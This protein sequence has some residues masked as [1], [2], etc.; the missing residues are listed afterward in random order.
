M[1]PKHTRR[2]RVEKT[3]Q[4]KHVELST[5]TTTCKRTVYRC[6]LDP[7]LGGAGPD[8]DRVLSPDLAL[9]LVDLSLALCFGVG[10]TRDKK[11]HHKPFVKFSSRHNLAG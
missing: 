5:P 7:R 6:R 2:H 4:Q 8:P 9:D 11:K 1:R 10:T 3:R